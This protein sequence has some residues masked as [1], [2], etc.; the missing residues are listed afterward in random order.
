MKF[1]KL[2]KMYEESLKGGLGDYLSPEEIA[3]KHGVSVKSILQ[4][5][6]M[7]IKVEYEHTGDKD[8]SKEIAIDHL[9]EIPDY[10]TRLANMERKATQ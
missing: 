3:Q 7:G 6:K 10:Y 8:I 2:I 9:A 5:L 4:Q 1:D